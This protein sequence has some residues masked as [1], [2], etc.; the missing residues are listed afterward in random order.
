MRLYRFGSIPYNSEMREREH[1][2]N[3][4]VKKEANVK[5]AGRGNWPVKLI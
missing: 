3:N 4:N 2:D 1:N 5:S